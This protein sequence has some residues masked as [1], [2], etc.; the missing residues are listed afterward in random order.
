MERRPQLRAIFQKLCR[1]KDGM[2]TDTSAWTRIPTLRGTECDLTSRWRSGRRR[3]IVIGP[4]AHSGSV[5]EQF[6]LRPHTNYSCR[7]LMTA[8][9]VAIR[10]H[11]VAIDAQPGVSDVVKRSGPHFHT[12]STKHGGIHGSRLPAPQSE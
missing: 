11:I 10:R 6:N 5:M 3:Q 4:M 2:L 7:K 8:G 9:I 1:H 12:A